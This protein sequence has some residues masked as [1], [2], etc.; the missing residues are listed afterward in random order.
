MKLFESLLDFKD[1]ANLEQLIAENSEK[2]DQ[3]F[4]ELMNNVINQVQNQKDQPELIK[5]VNSVYKAVL[6]YSMKKQMQAS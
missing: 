4:L 1:E 2:I 5:K 6:K 3:K